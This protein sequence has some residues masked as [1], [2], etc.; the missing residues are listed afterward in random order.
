M[1]FIRY[2][3]LK[4][5]LKTRTLS[6]REALPYLILFTGLA[7][8]LYL[9]PTPNEFNMWDWI[10]GALS[11]SMAVGSVIYAYKQNGGRQ[12]FDLIQK[13]TVMGWVVAV[14]CILAFIPI[15]FALYLLGEALGVTSDSTGWFDVLIIAGFEAV[16]Y[17][18]V[19]RHI[20]DT[21]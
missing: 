2:Q 18:R 10:G 21:R 1:N 8:A 20:R 11:V 13:Y 17:Q 12:G 14:R 9:V 16:F 15:A 5:K 4:E 7:A 3:P 6:D 19:G